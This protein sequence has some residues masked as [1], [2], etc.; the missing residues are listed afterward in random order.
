M[1]VV[2]DTNVFISSFL[3]RGNPKQIIDLWKN[4]SLTICLSREIIDEY[5]EVLI[6]LGIKNAREIEELLQ[7]FA[8]G[9]HSI[10]TAKI[11]TLK[12]VMEDPDDN[13]FFECAVSLKA[14]YIISGDK[15]VLKVKDYC[16]IKVVNPKYFLTKFEGSK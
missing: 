15:N 10:F 5:V 2:I 13:K 3:G 11:K 8:Q 6:R 7:L 12:I 4:G 16:G 9:Y 14:R 1:R